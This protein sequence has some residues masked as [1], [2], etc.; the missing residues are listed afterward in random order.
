M[1]EKSP[2]WTRGEDLT[3]NFFTF[4]FIQVWRDI[5]LLPKHSAINHDLGMW[6]RDVW[7]CQRRMWTAPNRLLNLYSTSWIGRNEVRGSGKQTK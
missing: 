4:L 7:T 3:L 6:R 5:Y 2:K 1:K